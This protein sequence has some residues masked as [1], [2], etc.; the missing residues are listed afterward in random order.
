MIADLLRERR[1]RGTSAKSM[2]KSL[3]LHTIGIIHMCVT[4]HILILNSYN[5][6]HGTAAE[7]QND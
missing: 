5:I 4:T 3:V 6:S 7:E 2:P 1:R